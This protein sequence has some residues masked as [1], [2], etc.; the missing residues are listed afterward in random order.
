M[1][2]F[3]K[4]SKVSIKMFGKNRQ[5]DTHVKRVFEMIGFIVSDLDNKKALDSRLVRLGSQHA[6][7]AIKKEYFL[8]RNNWSVRYWILYFLSFK[9]K[10]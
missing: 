3:D 4:D 2:Y 8:V 7:F 10:L 9:T 6:K 1:F 5:F